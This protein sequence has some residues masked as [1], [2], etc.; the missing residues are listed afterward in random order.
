MHV[1]TLRPLAARDRHTAFIRPGQR[2]VVRLI[3]VMAPL[4]AAAVAACR[5]STE[6]FACE[7]Q[8][9]VNLQGTWQGAA[10]RATLTVYLGQKQV[11]DFAYCGGTLDAGT[12]ADSTI[13]AQGA[14]A[15]GGVWHYGL[16]PSGEGGAVLEMDPINTGQVAG[17]FIG[18]VSDTT[19]NVISG[20]AIFQ[21]VSQA[22]YDTVAITMVRQ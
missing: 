20:N 10:P 19:K 12:Y 2:H 3:A 18:I 22:L 11:V 15:P 4:L 6:P 9:N 14:F 8:P 7:H 5:S 16:Q 21:N 13:N 1:L 17:G